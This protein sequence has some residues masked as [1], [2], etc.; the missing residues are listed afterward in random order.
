MYSTCFLTTNA[1]LRPD[2]TSKSNLVD[3]D[4]QPAWLRK[5][6]SLQKRRRASELCAESCRF[7]VTVA[8]QYR[9]ELEAGGRAYGDPLAALRVLE[10]QCEDAEEAVRV[11]ERRRKGL[12]A[13][14][15]KAEV[16]A[17]EGAYV[18]L[19]PNTVQL[20]L[21]ACAAPFLM[22]C[23]SSLLYVLHPLS[24][25]RIKESDKEST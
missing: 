17:A 13:V 3:R 6:R 7:A 12:R 21:W 9:K 8:R 23:C 11:L 24:A 16:D 20:R 19:K 2:L 15:E 25:R 5:S 10:A 22:L 4:A 18:V 1:A 14:Q